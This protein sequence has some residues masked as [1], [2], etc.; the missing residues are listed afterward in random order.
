[1]FEVIGNLAI[2][3][4]IELKQLISVFIVCGFQY[5]G[6]IFS[7]ETAIDFFQKG[8]SKV[9]LCFYFNIA[10]PVFIIDYTACIT[11]FKA[12]K[13]FNDMPYVLSNCSV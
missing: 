7:I 13:H 12:N 1:M 5:Q 3:V 9:F 6:L 4:G 10:F 8:Y 11:I 2:I